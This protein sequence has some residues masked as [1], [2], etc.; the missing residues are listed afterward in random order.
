MSSLTFDKLL[1]RATGLTVVLMRVGGIL[2]VRTERLM[3]V[4]LIPVDTSHTLNYMAMKM[5]KHGKINLVSAYGSILRSRLV[6]MIFTPLPCV[7]S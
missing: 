4:A 6:Q 1:S 2:L 3:G 7:K 5:S